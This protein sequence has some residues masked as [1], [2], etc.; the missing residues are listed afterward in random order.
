M[1]QYMLYITGSILLSC[2]FY[3][4]LPSLELSVGLQVCVAGFL[5]PLIALT[6]FHTLQRKGITEISK[7]FEADCAKAKVHFNRRASINPM[8]PSHNALI[9]LINE[10]FSDADVHLQQIYTSV[11]RLVPIAKQVSDSQV[12]LTQSS[13]VNNQHLQRVQVIMKSLEEINMLVN[14][15]VKVIMDDIADSES[16]VVNNKSQ[17]EHSVKLS[18]QLSNRL[19]S[20]EN[21]TSDLALDSSEIANLVEAVTSISEQTNL[22]ALNAAIEAARAG[23]HGRGF[24]V[25]AE[26]VR[27]LAIQTRGITDQ[28]TT[29]ASDINSKSNLIKE[30]ISGAN[31]L[32]VKTNEQI[33]TTF[34]GL[35]AISRSI[36]GIRSESDKIIASISQQETKNKDALESL[37]LLASHHSETIRSADIHAVLPEDLEKLCLTIHDKFN[38]FGISNK[39]VDHALREKTREERKI[40]AIPEEDYLFDNMN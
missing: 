1:I 4:A 12:A 32:A 7:L 31:D 11:S 24:A 38:A 33:M 21:T 2:I 13:L 8:T 10:A 23:E 5:S 40:E 30:D 19:N 39:T 27:N 20:S 6:I 29:L 34:E 22:L 14:S 16:N 15:D 25:V 17:M 28:I 26:E 36:S 3:L 35:T 9:E 37:H 18:E